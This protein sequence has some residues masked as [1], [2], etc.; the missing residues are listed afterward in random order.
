LGQLAKRW[1]EAMTQQ[2]PTSPRR[3]SAQISVGRRHGPRHPLGSMCTIDQTAEMINVS[4]RTVRR[5]IDSGKL[6][7]HRFGR[8][9]R[10][11]DLDIAELIAASRD[12]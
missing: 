12:E 7:V 6:P 1:P 5:L 2:R 8:S 3:A 10:V 4:S 11:S 9:V